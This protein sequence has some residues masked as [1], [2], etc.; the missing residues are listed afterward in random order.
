VRLAM[1]Y[2]PEEMGKAEKLLETVNGD[3]R[4]EIEKETL[5]TLRHLRMLNGDTLPE[6]GNAQT[7]ESYRKGIAA[8]FSNDLEAAIVAFL[9]VL[10]RDRKLDN[11]GARKAL[12]AIFTM[13]T[14][15]HPL[16]VKYR[17]PFSMALY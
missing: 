13:L 5:N 16:S 6:S 9:D 15:Q 8:L 10:I 17:R 1:L 2:L 12:I 14:D 7:A 3:H 4:F 11:D